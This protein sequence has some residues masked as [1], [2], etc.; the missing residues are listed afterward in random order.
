MLVAQVQVLRV[1]NE[2]LVTVKRSSENGNDA[3]ED[4]ETFYD[5]T[6]IETTTV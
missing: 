6:G 3:S 5:T 4:G 1:L 2:T